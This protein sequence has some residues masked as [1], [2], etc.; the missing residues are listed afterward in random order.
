M[1][2]MERIDTKAKVE[3]LV[4]WLSGSKQHGL[5]PHSTSRDNIE[6]TS[7]PTLIGEHQTETHRPV[8]NGRENEKYYTVVRPALEA[9]S[10]QDFDTGALPIHELKKDNHIRVDVSSCLTSE[11]GPVVDLAGPAPARNP[12]STKGPVSIEDDVDNL[13][14]AVQILASPMP[15]DLLSDGLT[16]KREY[17]NWSGNDV[18]GD[19]WY[20]RKAVQEF[21]NETTI[22]QALRNLQ[23]EQDDTLVD[24]IATRARMLFAIVVYSRIPQKLVFDYMDFF[25]QSGFNDSSL[26]TGS[27]HAQSYSGNEFSK[28]GMATNPEKENELQSALNRSHL[29]D[30]AI[31]RAY[32]DSKLWVP[33]KATSLI[34][35]QWAILV[36]V[37]STATANYDFPSGMIMPFT[38]HEVKSGEQSGSFGR[39]QKIEIH[40]G[41]FE[42]PIGHQRPQYFALKEI[43]PLSTEERRRIQSIWANEVGRMKEMNERHRDHIVRLGGWGAKI[44]PRRYDIWSMGVISLEMIIWLLQGCDGVQRFHRSVKEAQGSPN[45]VTCYKRKLVRGKEEVVVEPKV[46]E[47]IEFLEKDGACRPGTTLRALLD[48]IRCDLLI[49]DVPLAEEENGEQET[50]VND[51][52]HVQVNSSLRRSK[53]REQEAVIDAG[54]PLVMGTRP[55]R[56]SIKGVENLR[57]TAADFNRRLKRTVRARG[58]SNLNPTIAHLTQLQR[59]LQL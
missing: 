36:P 38:K 19:L 42:D 39:V 6:S 20:P 37:F 51:F 5:T 32:P 29:N 2:L 47:W 56:A 1:P 41:Q 4:T 15:L 40:A 10:D 14:H 43:V 30:K 31:H 35:N 27:D 16:E 59:V 25:Q 58:A 23:C 50:K 49:P 13:G 12:A 17:S 8:E 18:Y 46:V 44:L 21:F 22:R 34:E 3:A 48:I 24:F 57:A 26:L 55:A 53:Q 28:N 52:S 9:K 45:R 33:G 54:H 11:N 7:V